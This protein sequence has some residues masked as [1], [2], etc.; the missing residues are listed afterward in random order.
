MRHS[1]IT[2]LAVCL[3]ASF[4][5]CGNKQTKDA[6]AVDTTAIKDSI[7]S[8]KVEPQ[9]DSTKIFSDTVALRGKMVYKVTRQVEDDIVYDDERDLDKSTFTESLRITFKNNGK[10]SI[11]ET[12][13]DDAT[14]SGEWEANGYDITI[15]ANDLV[16]RGT[17]SKDYKTLI[18][19]KTKCFRI[20]ERNAKISKTK[21]NFSRLY[22]TPQKF[23]KIDR[24]R[25]NE[26]H[27]KAVRT[28][29]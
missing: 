15:Y 5:A 27:L 12:L 19:R 1:I 6:K 10:V 20:L 29:S 14:W 17:V 2:A 24:L 21:R 23:K 9:V 28:S 16:L 13:Q 8:E 18:I 7:V 11:K 26:I 25:R 3:V 4:T 22:P